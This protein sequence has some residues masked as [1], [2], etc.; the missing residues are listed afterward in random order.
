[1]D[2]LKLKEDLLRKA[3]QVKKLNAQIPAFVAGAAEKMKDANFAAEGFVQNGSANPKWPK[4]RRETR[5]STGKRILHG[6]GHMQNNVKAKTLADRV[7][8]GVDLSKV[9]YAQI[10]DEGGKINQSVK[11]HSRK[12]YKTGKRYSVRAHN[13]T[14]D[15]PQRKFLGYTP[16]IDKITD[17][18]IKYQMDKI[19]KS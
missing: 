16:D 14:L 9:P 6:S 3:S 2:A 10:H 18:E 11:A 8:V 4:R 13:R 7:H 5:R 17:K 1:M 12:H 19:F 15:M